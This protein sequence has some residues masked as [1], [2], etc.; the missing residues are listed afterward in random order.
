MG[1]CL[2]TTFDYTGFSLFSSRNE[3][4]VV[5]QKGDLLAAEVGYTSK[6]RREKAHT[7]THLP[8]KSA[9]YPYNE[10]FVKQNGNVNITAGMN[11]IVFPYCTYFPAILKM[12]T[13][14]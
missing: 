10:V 9:C 2:F 6:G 12:Q 13:Y 3:F 7:H 4:T 8:T 14:V 5:P 11:R 1:I